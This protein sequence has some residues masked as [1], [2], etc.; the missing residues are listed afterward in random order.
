MCLLRIAELKGY[1][2]VSVTVTSDSPRLELRV[3]MFN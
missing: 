1:V 2:E 3:T